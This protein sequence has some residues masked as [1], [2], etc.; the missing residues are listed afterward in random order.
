MSLLVITIRKEVIMS[1]IKGQILGIILTIGVFSVVFAALCG[2][3]KTTSAGIQNKMQNALTA[4]Y[5]ET[6][7]SVEFDND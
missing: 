3:F 5:D 6:T 1:E 7:Q 4:T 2:A